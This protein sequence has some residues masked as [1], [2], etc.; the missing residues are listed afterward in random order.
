ML[1]YLIKIRFMSQLIA[2]FGATGRTGQHF[3]NLALDRG[4][5]VK[6]LVRNPRKIENSHE[7]LEIVIGDILNPD[8]VDAVVKDCNVVVSLI[9]H[10][11]DS[12]SN[13]QTKGTENIVQAMHNHGVKKIISMS[14]GA[15]PFPE[16]D[17]PKFIDHLFRGIMSLFFKNVIIDAKNHAEIL[18]DSG[19]NWVIVRGPRL[20]DDEPKGSYRVGWVGVDS[21]TKIARADIAAFILDQVKSDEFSH[22]M[23]FVS[24]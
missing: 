3:V 6:A 19:L 18:K 2:V 21:G 10:V 7:K 22:Q 14:G 24:Y 15:L 12:P 16:K 4:H 1:G 9:G 23:P 13:V 17:Q 20:T 11:K 8:E 5:R